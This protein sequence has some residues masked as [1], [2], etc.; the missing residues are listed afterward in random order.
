MGVRV[1]PALVVV[2]SLTAPPFVGL[3]CAWMCAH[4]AHHGTAA[5]HHGAHDATHQHGEAD[6]AAVLI[7]GHTSCDHDLGVVRLFRP[8][9]EH[10]T[11][12]PVAVHALCTETPAAVSLAG[13]P[14]GGWSPPDDRALSPPH[15]SLVLRI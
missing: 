13:H 10:R 5:A 11:Q 15:R 7:A 14:A 8:S 6:P 1:F 12:A 3:V 2:L 9:G 4:E